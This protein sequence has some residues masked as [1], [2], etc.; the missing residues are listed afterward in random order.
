MQHIGRGLSGR[1]RGSAVRGS[2]IASYVERTHGDTVAAVGECA[3]SVCAAWDG[4]E[5]DDPRAVKRPLQAVLE[6]TNT[7]E[8]LATVL[9]DVLAQLGHD[10]PA[11][12][13]P[14]PPY[15]VVTST[16]P[17]LRTTLPD[18]RLVISFDVFSVTAAGTY[19]RRP[20]TVAVSY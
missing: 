13:V 20:T 3:A 18:G 9:E 8:E 4:T 17:V 19:R 10:P 14:S 15:V 5:V 16:G 12:I 7:L 1:S 6:H 11:A 2:D